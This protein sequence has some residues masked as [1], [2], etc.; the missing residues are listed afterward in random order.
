VTERRA[1]REAEIIRPSRLSQE[2]V[3][4][5]AVAAAGASELL[6]QQF[7]TRYGHN[8]KPEE[9]PSSFQD[10]LLWVNFG[11][12]PPGGDLTVP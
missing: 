3:Y 11:I 1:I 9:I 4:A 12:T 2:H 7:V 6:V 5:D 10:L 8:L